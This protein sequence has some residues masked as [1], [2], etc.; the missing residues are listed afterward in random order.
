MS[1]V[2]DCYQKMDSRSLINV[3]ALLLKF[4]DFQIVSVFQL[5]HIHSV[6]KWILTDK[7]LTDDNDLEI[8][9]LHNQM[10]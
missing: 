8:K 9:K 4:E 2:K 1:P 5:S 6:K 3:P 10:S 7:D